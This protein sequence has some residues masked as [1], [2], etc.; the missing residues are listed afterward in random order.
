MKRIRF[1]FMAGFM[2]FFVAMSIHDDGIPDQLTSEQQE[3]VDVTLDQWICQIE[4]FIVVM[5][6]F[7]IHSEDEERYGESLILEA[8]AISE[9][10]HSIWND[11]LFYVKPPVEMTEKAER[12]SSQIRQVFTMT[13]GL[14]LT[15][16]GTMR[17]PQSLKKCALKN[18][19]SFV[20]PA[21]AFYVRL[22]SIGAVGNSRSNFRNLATLFA[23][24]C[25]QSLE[26]R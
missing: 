4:C 24:V 3:H 6:E 14:K 12:R 22:K 16:L 11:P 1:L 20:S 13:Q 18:L 5:E 17:L 7:T 21:I 26:S 2:A 23:Y 25:S 9:A 8:K 15:N 10:N 19:I